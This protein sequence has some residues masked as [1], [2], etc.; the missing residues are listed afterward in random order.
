MTELNSL[1]RTPRQWLLPFS[2]PFLIILIG[3]L[4]SK[5][6]VFAYTTTH[7]ID[8][9]LY[10][11]SSIE[12][13]WWIVP[14]WNTGV[15][16]SLFADNP[17]FIAILTGL[18]V[19]ALIAAYWKWYRNHHHFVD[20]AFGAVLGGALANAYDRFMTHFS[21]SMFGVRDFLAFTI[22]VIDYQWP[23]FNVAD[24]GISTGFVML[25]LASFVQEHRAS[26]H[27]STKTDKPKDPKNAPV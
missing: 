27:K 20:I 23:T 11:E 6:A 17:V 12:F 7:A 19:P 16:W 2:I 25:L 22:P 9:R 26:H 13:T 3:D 10:I 4:W 14:A 1:P 5:A 15:A 21:D 18:L 24:A 8:G